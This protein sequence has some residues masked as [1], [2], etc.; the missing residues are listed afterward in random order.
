MENKDLMD[1]KPVWIKEIPNFNEKTSKNILQMI[2][3]FLDWVI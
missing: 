3:K 2:Q 1:L